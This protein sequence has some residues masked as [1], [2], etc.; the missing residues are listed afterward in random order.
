MK[1]SR[2]KN[3]DNKTKSHDNIINYKNQRN[4]VV[5][6]N[7]KSKFKYFNKYDPNKQAK[8]FWVNCKL[9]FSKKHS[10]TDANIMLT[11]NG[12]LNHEKLGYI[13][14]QSFSSGL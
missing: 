14:F 1:K 12:E 3:Q 10:K 13:S 5:K 4:L 11:E 9:Y 8:P 2:H 7:K 6:L